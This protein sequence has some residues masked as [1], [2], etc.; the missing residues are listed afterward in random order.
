MRYAL[1][2][3][4]L[5]SMAL[6]YMPGSFRWQST[7]GLWEDDYD[8]LFEPARIPLID[9]NRVYTNLS[10][11]VSNQEE[12]FGTQTRNF[13]LVG[14]SSN[15]TTPLYPGIVFDKFCHKTP[16][17]T[18][19]VGRNNDSL[20]GKGRL[21]YTEL[22]DLD[23][24]GTYDYKRV[25]V[26]EAEAWN[27]GDNLDCY[28]G[29]GFRTGSL[30]LGFGCAHT[31]SSRKYVDPGYCYTF[32][33]TDSS[34]ITGLPTFLQSDSLEG[35]DRSSLSRTRFLLGGWYDLDYL[36]V[37]LNGGYALVSEN[38]GHNHRGMTFEDRSPANPAIVD[39]VETQFTDTTN[40]PYQGYQ[41]SLSTAA[42]YCPRAE[43]E[44][45]F[46][47]R[48]YTQSLGVA[49]AGGGLEANHIDSVCHPGTAT[50]YDS[51]F[52]RY[53][54]QRAS[55][56]MEFRTNQLFTL[57]DKFLL[58]FGAGFGTRSWEDSLVD[59]TGYLSFFSYDNGDTIS[60]REDY[61]T[62]VRSSDEWLN[63]TTGRANILTLPV[64]F[65]YRILYPLA[66]R[67]GAV[68]RITWRDVTSIEEL[69][70]S[71]PRHTRIEYGDGT[72][73]EF[74]GEARQEAGKSETVNTTTHSTEFSYGIGYCPID[75][76]Q[77]DIMGF[78]RLTNLAN[79][80]LSVTLKF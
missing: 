31:E 26:T 44:S 6:A 57:S 15:L 40:T 1:I 72:F 60:G 29:L 25:D 13:F 17:F 66:L 19:L 61:Q 37:G 59:T 4:V 22:K 71:S 33:R 27:Q 64:G 38:T 32:H 3:L 16:L 43:I 77:I 74:V 50:G 28:G 12:Q 73:S 18:G 65:E 45:R 76:L 55:Q 47:V 49:E 42:F 11:F 56:G 30:R 20:F 78:S 75:N 67:L 23:S 39:Y 10:N 62:T 24:N 48:L 9:G 46:Y 68:H 41:A 8:L 69:V 63:R 7:A 80:A 70:A 35:F 51:C 5:C 2:G 36:S 21:F 52:H 14:G 53:Y 34:L 79:W 58:G 54:G